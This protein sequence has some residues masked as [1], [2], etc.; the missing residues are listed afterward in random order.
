MSDN[1]TEAKNRVQPWIASLGI[2]VFCCAVFFVVMSNYVAQLS[3]TLDKIDMRLAAIEAR[4]LASAPAVAPI[5]VVIPQPAT[6]SP[7]TTSNTPS[8]EA[9]TFAAPSY[10]GS[11]TP[12]AVPSAAP[13]PDAAPEAIAPIMPSVPN[14]VAPLNPAEPTKH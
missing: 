3:K 11:G 9:P 8:V 12:D 1:V 7:T 14:A 6:I 4:P 2:S 10:S 5:N 13:A